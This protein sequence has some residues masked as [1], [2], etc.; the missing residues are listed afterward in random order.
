MGVVLT[1]SIMAAAAACSG[2]DDPVKGGELTD[3]GKEATAP[4]G[5]EEGPCIG[6]G[7]KW[8]DL[9]R[10]VFGPTGRPGSCSFQASCHGS[11]DGDGVLAGGIRCFDAK[12]CRQSFL[13]LGLVGTGD[14]TAPEQATLFTRVLRHRTEDGSVAG[15]M[16]AAPSSY[17]FAPQCLDRMKAWVAG[18]VKDD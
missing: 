13:E 1:A 7:T 15:F 4:P 6:S 12:G 14:A 18:G 8:S 11:E 2:S 3:A 16:P 9:Y 5:P 10:D 17:L